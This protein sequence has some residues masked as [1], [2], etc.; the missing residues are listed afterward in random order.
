MTRPSFLSPELGWLFVWLFCLGRVSG[1]MGGDTRV[2]WAGVE[3][4]GPS[5]AVTRSPIRWVENGRRPGSPRLEPRTLP[6]GLMWA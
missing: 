2:L 3:V 1:S 6:W 4:A 5:V